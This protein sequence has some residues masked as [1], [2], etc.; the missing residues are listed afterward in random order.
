MRRSQASCATGSVRKYCA[1]ERQ[2]RPVWLPLPGCRQSVQH[3]N[4]SQGERLRPDMGIPG[5]QATPRHNINLGLQKLLKFLL[6]M[7]LID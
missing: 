6:Q 4:G 3:R 7:E 2:S 5:L 1:H